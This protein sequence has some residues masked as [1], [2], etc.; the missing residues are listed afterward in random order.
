M[1]LYLIIE[2]S[3]GVSILTFIG[4]TRKSRKKVFTVSPPTHQ[5]SC[6][7][8]SP[9]FMIVLY[10]SQEICKFNAMITFVHP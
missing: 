3:I 5:I 7:G 4:R 10:S 1:S 9:I 2:V 6:F 8:L